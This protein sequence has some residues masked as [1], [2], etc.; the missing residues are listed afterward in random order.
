MNGSTATWGRRELSLLMLGLGAVA[1]VVMYFDTWSDMY[2][3]WR[4]DTTFS[5]ALLVVPV[6]AYLAWQRRD[7]L[8]GLPI[9]GSVIGGLFMLAAAATWVLGSVLRVAAVEHV[10]V[11]VMLQALFWAVLG[12]RMVQQLMLPIGFLI[13]LAP[14]G[15]AI[16]PVLMHA[17]ADLSVLFCQLTGI[18]VVREGMLLH[19]PAGSFEVAK[20][21]S[22]VKFFIAACA[23]SV[24]VAA[25]FYK[26]WMRRL[27]YVAF[28]LAVAVL[29]N[30][31]RAYILILI[32][33]LTDMRWDHDGWHVGLGYVIFSITIL[34]LI[35]LGDRFSDRT[36]ADPVVTT[37]VAAGNVVHAI[38]V[39][40]WVTAGLA[41]FAGPIAAQAVVIA[42]PEAEV[43]A[44]VTV[45]GEVDSWRIDVDMPAWKPHYSG[46]LAEG[47]MRY[48]SAQREQVVDV[49]L[50][51]YQIGGRGEGEMISYRNRIQHDANERLFESRESSIA[52]PSGKTLAFV[53][54]PIRGKENRLV[55]YWFEIGS[56]TTLGDFHGKLL[57]AQALL[58]GEHL[59]RVVVLTSTDRSYDAARENLESFVIAQA[60]YFEVLA[61]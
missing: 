1:I 21:C 54:T 16:V 13:F 51:A 23:I 58:Q 56:R 34:A 47:T 30:G 35:W 44:L 57:E 22:G 43:Q 11:V 53:E 32:G 28:F 12:T 19:I 9:E 60:E 10:A 33:H 29:M 18:P 50:G 26:S 5:H 20:A 27:A 14:V 42:P 2:R 49:Y 15:K 55:W 31:F 41:I 17:T 46:A 4:R 25:T 38:P 7:A 6:S 37:P 8:R 59:E 48:V 24:I 61:R 45:P 39:A 36:A 3:L 52:L 40:A